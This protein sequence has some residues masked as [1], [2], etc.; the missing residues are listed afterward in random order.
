MK[1]LYLD[2]SYLKEFEAEVKEVN[3]GKFIVLDKT[4]FYASGGGQPHDEGKLIKD[5]KEFKVVFV[6]KFEGKISHE[7]DSEGLKVGDKVKGVLDWERRY[8]LM[9]SHTASH[10]L[11][12][13]LHKDAGALITGN[14]LDVNKCRDDFSLE[15]YN[16]EKI[17]EYI[18]KANEIIKQNLDVKAYYLSKEEAMKDKELF[19]LAAG[20]KH[21][22]DK[23]R[24]IEIGN[25]DKQADG[26]TH[27]KNT[28]ECG[29]IKFLKCENKG[30]SNRRVYFELSV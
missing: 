29:V 2:D 14:Q 28:K 19:K 8:K 5:G 30:K 1:P 6:G 23:I 25:Y 10:V 26:G 21:E 24:I 9:R 11:S 12:A 13:V 20:F 15:D 4:V 22:L 7:V 16:P 17:K 18:E 27:V 3:N